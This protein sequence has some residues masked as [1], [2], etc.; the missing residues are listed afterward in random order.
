MER[1]DIA[2][3]SAA[4][5][6]RGSLRR[7]LTQLGAQLI[8]L[9]QA[10]EDSARVAWW[11]DAASIARGGRPQTAGGAIALRQVNLWVDDD[12]KQPVPAITS[13]GSDAQKMFEPADVSRSA[14]AEE[15]TEM[16]D[17]TVREKRPRSGGFSIAKFLTVNKAVYDGCDD[18]RWLDVSND[19][20][21]PFQLMK[22]NE[23]A[24]EANVR[25]LRSLPRDFGGLCCR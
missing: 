18:R 21:R 15:M 14:K 16:T 7:F 13:K 4:A 11:D 24:C 9:P 5:R 17:S 8:G 12:L 19:R 20:K 1:T 25:V 2:G 3:G 10:D 23:A 6:G 22:G